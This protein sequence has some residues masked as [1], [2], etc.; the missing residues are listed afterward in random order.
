VTQPL[1]VVPQVNE[2]SRPD[3]SWIKR[4][5][6]IIAVARALG[7]RIRNRKTKCWRVENHRNGDADPSLSFYEKGN[8]WRCFVC[9]VIGGNSNVDLVMGVL[10]CDVGSAV[11]WIADLFP[12]PNVK[13]GRPAGKTVPSAVPYR[14]GVLGSEWEVIARSGMWGMLSAA[15]RSILLTLHA[16][17]DPDTELTRLSYRGIMRYSGVRKMANVSSAIK[18]L[19]R[20]HALQVC[21]GQRVGITRKCSA[22]RVTLNDAKFLELCNAVCASAR[23]EIAQERE[24][25]ALLKAKR[26]RDTR[27][28]SEPSL[29]V[30]STTPVLC[31][32]NS[33]SK[34]Q[35]QRQEARTCEGLNLSSSREVHANKSLPNG[36]REISTS[37]KKARL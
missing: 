10:G 5:V 25:R 26:Q 21:R 22:Y 31:V 32:S 13:V 29:P 20:M 2:L 37:K 17:Q 7:L 15:E 28:P 24:Y 1:A 4:N 30:V 27:K 35:T 19:S 8:R 36:Q 16:F 3:V 11:R 6:S 18:E 34:A 9:D 33:D 23:Q 12:V 14:V